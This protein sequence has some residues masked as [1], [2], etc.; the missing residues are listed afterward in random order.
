MSKTVNNIESS[1]IRAAVMGLALSPTERTKA[2]A[3]CSL[4]EVLSSAIAAVIN[5]APKVASGNV[6]KGAWNANRSALK[7]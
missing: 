1:S 2:L 4:A 7:L 3:A 5:P 6:T